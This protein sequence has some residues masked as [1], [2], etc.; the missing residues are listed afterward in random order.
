MDIPPIE[1]PANQQAHDKF[2][3]YGYQCWL[4]V[5]AW[6]ELKPNDL[7]FAERAEDFVTFS[8][9]QAQVAQVKAL[10]GEITL[11]SES[12][13]EAINHLWAFQKLS[14]ATDIRFSFL[15]TAGVTTEKGDPFDG[16]T[17]LS[18]WKTAAATGN[19]A[20]VEALRAFL[21]A[22]E[23]V[24]K[25]LDQDVRDYLKSAT[26]ADFLAKIVRALV[27]ET[28]RDDD[29]GV[30]ATVESRLAVLAERHFGATPAHGRNLAATL[31]A[32][33]Y[34]VASAKEK[35]ALTA[36]GLLA[37]TQRHLV[38]DVLTALSAR[39]QELLG[40][41]F[42]GATGVTPNWFFSDTVPPIEPGADFSRRES[43]VADLQKAVGVA[44]FIVIVGSSGMGK[45]TL[46]Q[47]FAA[48]TGGNWLLFR[49]SEE[50]FR[51]FRGVQECIS[52]I[53]QQPPPFGLLIDDLP[54]ERLDAGAMNLM[55]GL[56]L[57]ARRRGARLV[58]TNQRP[59]SAVELASAGL[60]EAVVVKAPPLIDAEI[61]EITTRM[62]CAD[63]KIAERW[64][65]MV[66]AQTSGHPQLVHAQLIALRE[67][68]WPDVSVDEFSAASAAVQE[69]RD[70]K[71][72]LLANLGV[73]ETELL[74]RLSVLFGP[75]RRD[76]AL[77]LGQQ[78]ERIVKATA[79]FERLH[80]PWIERASSER[81][82]L[83]PLIGPS[84]LVGLTPE[85][86]K[87]MRIAA[88]EAVVSC[89]PFEAI[90][91]V[92][93]MLNVV[94]SQATDYAT[95]LLMQ[96]MWVPKEHSAG[97]HALLSWAPFM[98]TDGQPVFPGWPAVDFLFRVLQF[99]VAADTLP[100]QCEHFLGLCDQ[101]IAAERDSES[102]DSLRAI[103]A[104]S[105]VKAEGAP[106]PFRRL[107]WCIDVLR[108]VTAQMNKE[109]A[110]LPSK[111]LPDIFHAESAE[112][113]AE[114]FVVLGIFMR[115][116]RLSELRQLLE[117]LEHASD[118]DRSRY[119]R[120]LCR[121]KPSVLM[122]FDRVWL[123]EEK[124]PIRSWDATLALFHDFLNAAV[125]WG[126]ELF[127]ACA[128]R[129]ISVIENEYLNR[130]EEAAHVLDRL[131]PADPEV[132]AIIS[133]QRGKIAFLAK[134]YPE[135]Q[136]HFEASLSNNPW[137]GLTLS[138][139]V[140]CYQNA[141]T[142]AGHAGDWAA[143][144][145]HFL[146]GSELAAED[147]DEVR[148]FAMLADSAFALWQTGQ[149]DTAV[150]RLGLA[151]ERA[152][153]L[154]DP[155]SSLGALRALKAFGH[156]LNQ[157]AWAGRGR[158]ADVD[159]A[160]LVAGF[161]SDPRA[162]ER[163]R[164]L[165]PPN[166]AYFWML[167]LWLELDHLPALP[168]YANKWAELRQVRLPSLQY[169]LLELETRRRLKAADYATLLPL[170]LETAA[171]LAA[172]HALK[173]EDPSQFVTPVADLPP[174]PYEL[175]APFPIP[176][177][178]LSTLTFAA[179]S[180]HPVGPVL[181]AWRAAAAGTPLQNELT[182]L[183]DGLAGAFAA[184]IDD[185]TAAAASEADDW[186]RWAHALR[187]VTELPVAPNPLLV[188]TIFFSFSRWPV[189][190]FGWFVDT[191]ALLDR[192]IS[193]QWVRACE[194]RFA[195]SNPTL[196]VP[197]IRGLATDP[198][199][200][201]AHIAKIA[202]AA[203]PSLHVNVGKGLLDAVRQVATS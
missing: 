10:T 131:A 55:R 193:A 65:P 167:Y 40:G 117:T 3:G 141:G 77:A 170:A 191:M 165:P 184:P 168:R 4:T 78:L 104:F 76:H 84:L 49:A 42:A 138:G 171:T 173:I 147:E 29:S 203:V 149:H 162:D 136:R 44:A 97:L 166:V 39:R 52:L 156:M 36:A 19:L 81:F 110:N 56:A 145:A 83:S 38:P 161:C 163:L 70:R 177:L 37:A 181:E 200:T 182:N 179:L 28:G 66:A 183:L 118:E 172:L 53:A 178:L 146:A 90:D 87:A 27:W 201:V 6:L 25:N 21:A 1:S 186:V 59:P 106:V 139:V 7:L 135:A 185:S 151:L 126:N 115:A 114:V 180:S 2:R 132:A 127:A 187:V 152:P 197:E 122:A 32:D 73:D 8:D 116:G 80:G 30:R 112:D 93:A 75:F 9:Q 140:N 60:S 111:L 157:L 153:Q 119:L 14:P 188:V 159:H 155:R 67:R 48:A 176:I 175:L 35:V 74:T 124:K 148:A 195:F 174:Q 121:F 13:A 169:F 63:Q 99:E 20:K 68:G 11:R 142:A 69:A 134:R 130:P 160:P 89:K 79:A 123:A 50:S 137:R 22:D 102:A 47:L 58:F 128:A 95:P 72:I 164:E 24:G 120:A 41:V 16:V 62:G 17:G 82:Q 33:V 86:T 88:V 43:A 54:W 144:A 12:V 108:H 107:L 23:S 143:S 113:E 199:G 34:A 45:S 96:F 109:G 94:L 190:S 98:F 103:L 61:V 51:T 46:A 125:Q 26:P 158:A 189:R 15:T 105:L 100:A 194:Q 57:M 91:A 196:F 129:G 92:H 85:R 5:D 198:E 154:P 18:L 31:F 202:V 133:E 192:K 101:I 150:E 71:Q 64:A